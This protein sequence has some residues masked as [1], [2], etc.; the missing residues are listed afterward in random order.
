MPQLCRKDRTDLAQQV[1]EALAA[2][3]LT[4][5]DAIATVAVS[6][7]TCGT[8]NTFFVKQPRPQSGPAARPG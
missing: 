4:V 8:S 1:N 2:G 7:P 6:C 5:N 3:R